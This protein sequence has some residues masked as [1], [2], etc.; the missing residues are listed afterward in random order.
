MRT[1]AWFSCGAAS[2]VAA[3][4]TPGATLVYCAT[5]SEH[6][7]NERFMADVSAWCDRPVTILA[8]E[9]Y[10]ERGM[11]GPSAAIWRELMARPARSS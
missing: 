6:S 5:G 8:S 1:L 9:D 7:D 2:A 3:K 11:S 10:A 4:L